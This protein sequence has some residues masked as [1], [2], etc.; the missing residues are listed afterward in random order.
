[1]SAVLGLT[2][3][4]I[5][6]VVGLKK[7]MDTF[8]SDELNKYMTSRESALTEQLTKL[9]PNSPDHDRL[10]NELEDLLKLKDDHTWFNWQ[11]LI[12]SLIISM[13]IGI[14]AGIL[15]AIYVLIT[16]TT[17]GSGHTA[18]VTAIASPGLVNIYDGNID[19]QVGFLTTLIGA[20]YAGTDFIE[21]F[22][23]NY[24]P[25]FSTN[26]KPP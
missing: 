18:N 14:I 8:S 6:V 11:E 26:K 23:N 12:V 25:S 5:R 19:I 16:S 2:G 20:G 24:T 22:M 9:E 10:V 3:Q 13:A 17:P 21:G 15:A 7:D 4:S 1:L